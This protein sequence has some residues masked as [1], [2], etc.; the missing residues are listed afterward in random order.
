MTK[1]GKSKDP[2]QYGSSLGSDEDE[3]VD[4][5]WGKASDFTRLH[6]SKYANNSKC[7]GASAK[8]SNKLNRSMSQKNTDNSMRMQNPAEY[9]T[10]SQYETG[11]DSYNTLGKR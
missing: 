8:K 4:D 3:E 9:L 2:I 11:I 5:Q 10:A 6:S 7:Q 1:F